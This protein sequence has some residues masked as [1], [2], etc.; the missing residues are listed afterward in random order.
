MPTVG[1]DLRHLFHVKIPSPREE[2]HEV[3]KPLLPADLRS[4]GE[5]TFRVARAPNFE[6]RRRS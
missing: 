2:F 3:I 1:D 4:P 6:T 5:A